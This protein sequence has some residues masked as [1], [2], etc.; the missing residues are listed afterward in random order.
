MSFEL[1]VV[2][3]GNLKISFISILLFIRAF[4][5]SDILNNI[6]EKVIK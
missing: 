2:V 1:T 6:N 3:N 5:I 4:R